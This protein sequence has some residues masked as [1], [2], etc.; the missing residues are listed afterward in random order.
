VH[1]ASYWSCLQ[2]E[3]QQQ[4]LMWLLMRVR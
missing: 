3:G 1:D 2:L 4:Q